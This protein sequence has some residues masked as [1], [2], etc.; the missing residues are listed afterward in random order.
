ML[1]NEEGGWGFIEDAGIGDGEVYLYR[2][3]LLAGTIRMVIF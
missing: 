1:R 2:M 3:R